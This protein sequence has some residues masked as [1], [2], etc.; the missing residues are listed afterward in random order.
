[1]AIREVVALFDDEEEMMDTIDELEC[2]GFDRSEI[3]ILPPLDEVEE[4]LGHQV[5]D[6]HE[7]FYD[8]KTPRMFPLDYASWGDAQGVLI[9]APFMAGAFAVTI[10]G[11]S[12]GMTLMNTILMAVLT[13][14]VGAVFGYLIMFLLK[15][16]HKD[17]VD[18]QIDRGGLAM[19]VHV[20]D[21]AHA[22]RAIRIFNR[23]HAHDI[24]F[25]VGG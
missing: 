23:H 9:A 15:K 2:K 18:D 12:T 4:A 7:A 1:M 19:W 24:Q 6:I 21:T 16:R 14:S 20:R 10:F 3:S 25:R 17:E 22:R 13:G 11:A 8:P 5:D